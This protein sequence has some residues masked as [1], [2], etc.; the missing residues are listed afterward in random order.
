METSSAATNKAREAVESLS[1]HP[2]TATD[3]TTEKVVD[4]A[5]A[6]DGPRRNR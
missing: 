4:T 6:N 3:A 1:A 5:Q 2:M